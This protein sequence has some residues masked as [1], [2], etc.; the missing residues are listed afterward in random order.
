MFACLIILEFSLS[1]RRFGPM[2]QGQFTAWYENCK[3]NSFSGKKRP[4]GSPKN[5]AYPL[6]DPNFSLQINFLSL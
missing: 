2:L 6:P 5:G 1:K 4:V 3:A